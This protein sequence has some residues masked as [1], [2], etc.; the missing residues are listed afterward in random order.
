MPDPSDQLEY[1]IFTFFS[2]NRAEQFRPL[3]MSLM[4]QVMLENLDNA[5]YHN[6]LK[7]I[8]NFYICYKIIGQ[9]NSN[10]LSDTVYKYA[11]LIENDF[12]KRG[13]E[14]CIQAL[15]D[16]LPTLDSFT[17]S[18]KNVGW[19]NHWGLYKDS[20]NKNRCHLVLGVIE[21]YIS[22]RDVNMEV[23][24][25]HIKPDCENIENAQIGNLLLLERDLNER[26]AGNLRICLEPFSSHVVKKSR[27]CF[28]AMFQGLATRRIF[29][30]SQ[31]ERAAV[32]CDVTPEKSW[33]FLVFCPIPRIWG[34]LPAS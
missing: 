20:K 3:L 23:T 25:E 4:N 32:P 29:C 5:L 33:K 8:Y 30:H 22:N 13:L 16:K 10:K 7:F 9:E 11:Y 15:K 19:S 31:P 1:E 28:P 34:T 27:S 26:C 12:S 18:F 2:K 21:K 17:N 6:A 24:I 14:E